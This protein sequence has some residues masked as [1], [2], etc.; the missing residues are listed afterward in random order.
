MPQCQTNSDCEELGEFRVCGQNRCRCAI[1]LN[2]PTCQEKLCSI[3]V[4]NSICGT[5]CRFFEGSFFYPE[6][7][8]LT[9]C[10]KLSF[11]TAEANGIECCFENCAKDIFVDLAHMG[12]AQAIVDLSSS[13]EISI[14]N[15]MFPSPEALAFE[16]AALDIF[17][18][19][20]N[21]EGPLGIHSPCN[22]A[23]ELT[24][25]SFSCRF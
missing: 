12:S 4:D 10:G 20:L 3:P 5:Y 17:M 13:L 11:C 1:G 19:P 15:Q 25:C 24:F 22:L 16:T 9:A 14:K 18:R 21:M 23:Y 6:S 8:T 7:W 2:G